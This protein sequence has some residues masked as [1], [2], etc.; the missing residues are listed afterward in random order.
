MTEQPSTGLAAA[1]HDTAAAPPRPPW[2][3]L[4]A[5]DRPSVE[6]RLSTRRIVV[7]VVAAAVVVIV[8]V[9]LTGAV[10]ARR[11]AEAEAVN[12]AIVRAGL[13]SD[14]LLAP[15]LT[16][17]VVAG[18]ALALAA[19]DRVVREQ[20]L[21]DSI[22]RV[23]VWTDEGE[24]VYS[25]E[26]RLVGSR[27]PLGA[28]EREV[29]A[30]PQT[31]AEVSDL[32]RPENRYE[33]GRGK[34]LE[35]YRPV[36]TLPGGTTVLFETYSPYS[37]VTSRS[38]QLW[39]GF[40]GLMI[41]SLLLLVI[42]LVP[43]LWRLLDRVR[44]GQ[45]QRESLLRRAVDASNTERRRIAGTLHDGVV[46]E[47]AATSF[48]LA[49]AVELAEREG[50]PAVAAQLRSAALTVRSSIGGLRSLL[51]DIYPPS[52]SSAGLAVA[53]Q[54][55][56]G[57]LASR[58]VVVRYDLPGPDAG[59]GLD[60]E[61]ERLV[62][63]IAHECLTNVAKHAAATSVLVRLARDGQHAVLEVLDDGRGFDPDQAWQSPRTGHL[64]LRVLTDLAQDA[65]ATLSVSS[66]P[67]QGTW[68]RLQ[69]PRP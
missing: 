47:L 17:G 50:S 51:V 14:S 38:T 33:R 53:L 22:V 18:D 58:G 64:G 21:S 61:G 43:V 1:E 68:W 41:S 20:V 13:V 48:T 31:R 39:R 35:V 6:P 30:D 7:Q 56:A 44:L 49:G 40:A 24:I 15:V 59:T 23:K 3:V 10:A 69:V 45:A 34:L 4:T 27:F 66:A 9:A 19:L 11:L 52:L 28:D 67:G 29:L 54:D 62:Y 60:A 63:R 26:P 16:D 65:G 8:A 37:E 36:S 2:T 5:G 32:T 46:Q 25:D 42:L 55:L 12:D 57:P